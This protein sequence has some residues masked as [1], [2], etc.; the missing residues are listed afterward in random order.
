MRDR[1]GGL[2]A[3]LSIP[4]V[5]DLDN[6]LVCADLLHEGFA[7]L[8]FSNPRA[9]LASLSV[10]SKGR[11][12][13]KAEIAKHGLLDA[14]SVPYREPLIELLSRE[15]ARGRTVHLVTAADEATAQ[16]IASHVGLFDSVAGSDGTRNLKGAEKLAYL[17]ARFPQG[18]LYAGDHASDVPLFLASRGAILCDVDLRTAA[19]TLAGATVLAE[20]RRPPA[21]M[22]IWLRAARVHQW[23]KNLLIFVPLMLGHAYTDPGNV[24]TTVAAFL[25]TCVLASAAY[26][27]NDIS[28]LQADRLHQTKRNRPFASGELPVA[29]GLIGA[30]LLVLGAMIGAMLL[31]PPFALTLLLYLALTLGYSFGLK[32]VP[33]FDVLIIGVLFMLRIVMGTTVIGLEFSPW[34]LS[35]SWAFFLSLALTKRHVEIVYADHRGVEEVSGRGYR[36]DDWPLTLTFGVGAGLVSIVI[37]LLYLAN[38]AAP[39]GLYTDPEWLYAMPALV[40]VWLMR[41]WL[42][43]HRM[44]LEADPVVFA[45]QDRQS[46]LLG[47]LVAITFA[48]AL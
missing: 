9:A 32:R 37:V 39:S 28:D 21:G 38:D 25:L 27:I 48:V 13:L 23:S 2:D 20:L 6:T 36:S 19:K 41:I 17:K 5:V 30:P 10:L 1:S 29:V 34:L 18:F 44:E 46:W 33:L 12:A 16:A 7:L 8:L 35:F 45:L 42:L 11:A 15:R 22:R 47:L 24:I 4:L 31:S 14:A 3:D 26:M 43:A 40:T